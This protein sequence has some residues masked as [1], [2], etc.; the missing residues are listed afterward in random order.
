[1]ERRFGWAIRGMGHGKNAKL[2]HIDQMNKSTNLAMEW[3]DSGQ[4]ESPSFF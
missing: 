1:M 2:K 4:F 3:K